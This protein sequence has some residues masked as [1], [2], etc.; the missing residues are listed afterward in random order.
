MHTDRLV[1]THLLN[2]WVSYGQWLAIL[3]MTLEH[4]F[5]F[6]WPDSAFTPWAQS[7]GR[8][9]FPL[10]AAIMA[11]HL[12]HNSRQPFTYGLR[13]LLIGAVSQ[14]P[15]GLIVTTGKLNVCFT[16]AL[17]LLAVVAFD[18]LEKQ[19]IKGIGAAALLALAMLVEPYLEYGLW[20][21]LL[22]PAFVLGFRYP[23]HFVSLLPALVF[24]AL[25]NRLELSIAISFATGCA[26]FSVSRLSLDNLP[27]PGLPR[28]LRLSWYPLHLGAIAVVVSV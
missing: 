24:C 5:R 21:L 20:G 10:F 12:V 6:V 14:V 8:T 4:S 23:E 11:W 25:I 2:T 1:T 18:R 9:A 16:L 28:W 3:T 19:S 22:V 26:I 13:V 15:Y 27:Q 7:A 17:G